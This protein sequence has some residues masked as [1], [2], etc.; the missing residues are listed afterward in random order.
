MTNLF[1]YISLLVLDQQRSTTS[2]RVSFP[3]PMSNEVLIKAANEGT[4]YNE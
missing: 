1:R 4:V 2:D 3:D